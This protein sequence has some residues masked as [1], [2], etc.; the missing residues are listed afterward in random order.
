MRTPRWS[1]RRTTPAN[2][3]SW[4][5]VRPTSPAIRASGRS[6]LGDG[7]LDDRVAVGLDLVGDRVE[8]GG[9]LLRGGR[10]VG[11]GSASAAAAVGG[12]DVGVRRRSAPAMIERR[13]ASAMV[14]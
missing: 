8:E 7:G 13:S 14:R 1:P 6:A 5:V 4:P 12:G 3:R 9:A 10:A 2:S 11:R